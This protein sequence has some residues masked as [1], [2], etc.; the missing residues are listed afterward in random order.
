MPPGMERLRQSS[1][2]KRNSVHRM[3]ENNMDKY[4]HTHTHARCR[5]VKWLLI[6]RTK[7][8]RMRNN[9]LSLPGQTKRLLQPLALVFC[10]VLGFCSGLHSPCATVSEE[11]RPSLSQPTPRTARSACFG[12]VSVII[13][14]KSHASKDTPGF[15]RWVWGPG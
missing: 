8:G 7:K 12:S 4:A 5:C 1:A 3:A 14:I 2:R 13:F 6:F 10:F 9:T 11:E 15:V